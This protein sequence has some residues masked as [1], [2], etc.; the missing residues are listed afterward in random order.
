M[1]RSSASAGL[2]S[3]LRTS[4]S[5]PPIAAGSPATM[6]ARMIIEMPLP[7][8]RS[9]ICSPSHIR[10]MVPAVSVSV[11]MN[12]N[13]TP[14]LITTPWFWNATAAPAA[15][16]IASATVPMRVYC[17]SL[18]LPASPSLRS[19]CSVGTTTAIIC[20]MID[21]EMYGITPS[22][23]IDSRSSAPPENML[24]MLRIVPCWSWNR[25]ASAIRVDARHRN[26]SADAVDDQSAEQEEESSPQLGEPA[27]LAE[28][29]DRV[30]A[31]GF[32]HA[33]SSSS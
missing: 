8:P 16:K 27:R 5:V 7:R 15:W 9:V 18:R 31:G 1:M 26:E 32:R 33:L 17:V 30:A 25:R 11:A 20:T 21:A 6:P 4:S 3:P 13:W 23:R 12:T 10:N 14:G 28:G 24:N 22:A 29:G 19:A 2:I